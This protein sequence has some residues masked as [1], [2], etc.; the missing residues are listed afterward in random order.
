[1][2]C[3]SCT[4][5]NRPSA[6]FC[7]ECGT[8]LPR[9]CA[10]CG[11]ELPPDTKFCDECGAPQQSAGPAQQSPAVPVVDS[12]GTRKVV[13]VLFADLAGSTALHERLDPESA[14]RFME[15]Y[16]ALARAAVEGE[17][18]TVAKLLGD[19]VLAVFGIPRVAEDDAI[20]A[21]RAGVAMQ[22][23]FRALAAGQRTA[24]GETGLRV[25]VNT[26]EVVVQGDEILG[27]PVNVAARLQERGDDGDVVIGEATRRLVA[28]DLSLEL[29]GSFDLKG[30][31]EAVKA[32]RVVSLAAPRA[33]ATAF[34]GREEELAR[35]RAVYDRAVE[36]PAA[37][38][39]VLVGSPGLGKSRLID[40]FT[41]CCGDTATIVAARCD[42]AG[43]ATFA[44]IAEALREL[45]G[46]P[47]QADGAE[48]SDLPESSESSDR[49]LA[50]Q[51]AVHAA[52]PASEAERDRIAS[53]VAAL[54]AGSPG[55]PEE[56]FFVLRRFLAGLA[57]DR[58]VVLVIDDLQW[59]EPLLLD[60]V[61]HLIQWGRGLPLLVLV[62]AR[63]ELREVRSSLAMPGGLVADVV[64]LTALDAGVAMRL[65][66]GV[67][68]AADLPAAVAA[69]VLAT[70]EGNPLFIAELVRMLVDEGAL[71][72]DGNRW[73]TGETLA[74]VEMPPTIHALL[75]ARIE[76]LD[77]RQCA[78]LE[79]A[80]VVG[81][82]FSRS[83]VA[84]LLP[85]EGAGLDAHLEALER[86]QLIERDAG[87]LLGEPV[88]RFHHMLIRDAAYRR[89]LK[90]TRAELHERLANW[91]EARAG[92]APEHEETIGRHL[93]EAHRL[94]SELGPV[95]TAG[96]RLGER[97]ATRLAAAGR[98][99]LEGDDEQ[100]AAGLLGRALACLQPDDALRT[101]LA[102][103]LCEA[104]LSAGDVD[105]AAEA[106]AELERSAGCEGWHTC[107]T[108][109][110]TVLTAPEELQA[111]V[112]AVGGAAAQFAR[113]GDAAGEAKAC[114][115]QAL[116]LSRLGKVGACEAALDQALAAARRG[117]DRR[118]ANTVLAIA[119]LAALWGPSPVTR[120]SGR[121]LDVVRV[122]R[123]TRGAPAVEAVALSC[124]GV[125][126]AL[127]G[128][129]DAAHRMIASGREM[130]EEL[131]IAQRLF[132][133]DVFAGFVAMLEGDAGAAE[134]ILRG[135][136]DGLRELGLGIDAARAAAL[137]ARA[138]LAQDRSEEAAAL[139]HESEALAGDDLKAAIAWRG[140]RAE[141]LAKRGEHT[142]AID[143]ARA[144]VAIAATTDAL[145]DH[146]DARLALATALRAAGR[147]AE[148]D[149]EHRR[150]VDLLEAKGATLLVERERRR[151]LPAAAVT[152]ASTRVVQTPRRRSVRANFATLEARR[153]ES[154][155][156]ERDVQA[157]EGLYRPDAVIVDHQF[158]VEYGYDEIFERIRMF[159]EDSTDSVFH[160]DDLATLGDF[161]ALCR[162]RSTASGSVVHD[163]AFGATDMTYLLVIEA[164]EQGSLRR[165]DIFG[166]D[167]LRDAV[168]RLYGRHAE[169][170]P[171]GAERSHAAA[172]AR[173]MARLQSA[174]ADPELLAPALAPD[175]EGI[176]H[177]HLRNWSLSGASAYLEHLRALHQV[178]DEVRFRWQDV[179]ALAPSALLVRILHHG[180][181]RLGG[182]AY[183][184]GFLSL[185]VVGADGRFTRA[186]WFDEGSEDE[187]LA[188]FEELVGGAAHGVDGAAESDA[189]DAVDAVS[190][191][192]R[193]RLRP[194]TA[195]ALVEAI[196]AGFKAR[197][198]DALAGLLSEPL[199][200]IEHPTGVT[201]GRQGQL[202]SI[203]RMLGLPNLDFRL[204]PLA[205][206]ADGL[207]LARRRVRAR[208]TQGGRFDVA[209]YEMDHLVL[210]DV[211]EDGVWRSEVFSAERLGAAIGR[212]YALHA[213]RLG[214]GAQATR[215]AGISGS[216]SAIDAPV[217]LDRL[218][219]AYAENLT[220]IDHRSMAMWT[221]SSR[222]ELAVHFSHQL[223]LVHDWAA[224][225]DD[226][227]A[228][229][230]SMLLVHVTYHGVGR[231]S[232]GL[233]ENRLCALYHFGDDGRV[234]A[235]DCYW[236][237][238]EADALARFDALAGG[239][240]EA[241]PESSADAF[242]NTAQ[243]VWT[244]RVQD[245][246]ARDWAAFRAGLA[247]DFRCIDRRRSSQV[248]LDADG[249]LAFERGLADMR[250]TEISVRWLATRGDRLALAW[251]AFDILD[252]DIGPSRVEYLNVAE[253]GE[254]G[255][256]S[257]L[258]RFDADDLDAARSMLDRLYEVGEG[259]HDVTWHQALSLSAA[260][261]C[262]DLDA[263]RAMLAPAFRVR[264]H[265]T[266]SWGDTLRDAETFL[267]AQSALS[268]LSP[269]WRY[270]IDH[271]RVR[272]LVSL[273][274]QAQVGTREGGPFE[275]PFLVVTA[276]DKTGLVL[277][278]DIYDLDQSERA[279]ARFEELTGAQESNAASR[280]MD[281]WFDAYA[282]AFEADTWEELKEGC[283]PDFVF[284]DR[285]RMVLLR[286][287]ADLMVASARERAA[288]G[289]R[290]ER[291]P[292][293]CFGD[294]VFV[295]R[296]LWA[297]GPSQ[298]R[299]EIEYLGVVECDE[300]GLLVAFVLFDLDDERA[301]EREALARQ[302]AIEAAAPAV[303]TLDGDA[304]GEGAFR[305]PSVAAS[306][307][308]G[309]LQ[310]PSNAATR[311]NERWVEA[312]MAG[313]VDAVTR[314][315]D[316]SYTLED[317]RPLFRTV[318]GRDTETSV[319][320]P[321]LHGGG[322]RAART[323]L[324][325]LGDRLML[326]RWLWTRVEE[327]AR[328]EIEFLAMDEIDVAGRF[329]RTI[330][331]EP[332][333]RGAASR[334]LLERYI[335]A[336]A[337]GMPHGS[338]ESMRAWNEHDLA[339][340]RESL[341][342]DF[343]LNDHRLAG[344]GRLEGPD[345]YIESV[346]ALFELIPDVH[347]E[348]LYYVAVENRGRVSVNR[349]WGTN[350]EGG[351]VES[352]FVLLSRFRDDRTSH[353]ELFEVE[354]LDRALER[355]AELRPERTN[356]ATRARER[357]A[358]AFAT[359]DW[360][361][362]RRLATA[363]FV[364]DDRGKRALV[365]GDIEAWIA[366]MQFTSG[367]GFQPRLELLGTFGDRVAMDRVLWRGEPGGDAFEFERI[368]VL[369]ADEEGRM[370]A[371]I[372]FD[373]ED[374]LQ[375]S[376]EALR[377]FAEVEHAEPVRGLAAWGEA[378]RSR[379]WDDLRTT[380]TPGF[381]AVDH[382]PL[383]VLGTLDR[384]QWVES[385]EAIDG[386]AEGVTYAAREVLAWNDRAIVVA[387]ART[388]TVTAGGGDIHDG[389][390]SVMRVVD[391]R[392][393][394]LDVFALDD[395]E[396]A[397][398][399]FD[400][401]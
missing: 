57:R 142:E 255:R 280:A 163:V 119:P 38:L 275:N 401:L 88:L 359:R 117:G 371:V 83:A 110:L 141:A 299:F 107:F 332:A 46:R 114:F 305:A 15:S 21:V 75:A 319:H 265:R 191:P 328:T 394:R 365:T 257:S 377:R 219:G 228:L 150:A 316:P 216:V 326:A 100:L 102:Q 271:H 270:R 103:D 261:P 373:P 29:L 33:A 43:G 162:L 7:R 183:E 139:S 269:D 227:L 105:A 387:V 209:D 5:E 308:A 250:T 3:P 19:G 287:D 338:F 96:R 180:S 6:K 357:Q 123:I 144:A 279:W 176:D 256:C 374:G 283:D 364:Y 284:D 188:R 41:R 193:R 317:R 400:G 140:V 127:R 98:R 192:P 131:G 133:T 327:D 99:A 288:M 79:R 61:E 87:W 95:D 112:D 59:A 108:G 31:A 17:G 258:H 91:I 146:A 128:R 187:A 291:R 201:Y 366:S 362:V 234:V 214:D 367:P 264:D 106:I 248:E 237:E 232:G 174:N 97:A 382:R 379:R 185:W 233:F 173:S 136:Y 310:I 177:R 324:A 343:V 273:G 272:G 63:P 349:T 384:E 113:S 42:A 289:A 292:V 259:R 335:A 155:V 34:V 386:L 160:H 71:V 282:R 1:M 298:G 301:L 11:S 354:H 65:A 306:D 39:A 60:L 16:Y 325:T 169:L 135:A 167:A 388:G 84:A 82:Q 339:R 350:R 132:E 223:D 378:Q 334:E 393:E 130:V 312:I 152:A 175:I 217:D 330:I 13:S 321:M 166:E 397:L 281:G 44:P 73:T 278:F 331:F 109:H 184:R 318:T 329:V 196:E 224:R 205:T 304:S 120:A 94:L 236:A 353:F 202:E 385:L 356:A 138:L 285:R 348:F 126:E 302:A 307:R 81:R 368:R 151:T 395:A 254:D 212:M 246:L 45:L 129:T 251:L 12:G 203:D 390:L 9:T 207:C 215:S 218:P 290:P 149:A 122:L 314:L 239:Q 153:A 52:I 375:A 320:L 134:R 392:L 294:R 295:E 337:D 69:K 309:A 238:G 86:A 14:R 165:L 221:C 198:R 190:R 66:A 226:V 67:I 26:G 10:S 50:L 18:G 101:D 220:L 341:T 360:D 340:L 62:G 36:T 121:C 245:A 231:D 244:Q 380:C 210:T 89:L 199:E 159:I 376:N 157:L 344:M 118:R 51:S 56:T 274:Q 80:A 189:I 181:E 389:F 72:R 54:L 8:P 345:A 322:W 293:R 158:G 194:N 2:N 168:A 137:L 58:P 297:G 48:A 286:G 208:G 361:A 358:A 241:P 303:G 154:V 171:E 206:L 170:L 247:P 225:I 263:C 398:A 266:L 323:I 268:E 64:A 315:L 296:I 204:E 230:P 27:D 311:G 391:G 240:A 145:L 77:P 115:V 4:C 347:T 222:D 369:E 30:R 352:F 381:V 164:D 76:R 148:A 336:G 124:Q 200:T 147:G 213:E 182:G 28:A 47:V 262:G 229:E 111:T 90:G 25:A 383:A 125:L 55:T 260:L 242:A 197:D 346:A 78:V 355:L 104:L 68:G 267:Q 49:V 313:D 399:C 23:A 276:Y 156:A 252:G 211:S 143:F 195:S 243:R 277:A 32:Y 37:H 333:D 20:R 178:A 351:E 70:S 116:A 35:I 396:G 253:V 342:A 22:E 179:L 40:E 74:T 235:I 300:N 92:A 372:F 161:V 186:E 172:T 85:G 93:E 24:V 249:Y 363:D 370:R 53:G